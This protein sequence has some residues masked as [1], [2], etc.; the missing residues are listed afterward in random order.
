MLRKTSEQ[1][2]N[3]KT[4][5]VEII[6]DKKKI[7]QYSRRLGITEVAEGE[8]REYGGKKII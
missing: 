4:K 5:E 8:T 3:T 2:N 1:Y 6:D 7:E